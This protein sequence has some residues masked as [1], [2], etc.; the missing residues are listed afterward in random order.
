V[1]RATAVVIGAGQAGLAM[2]RCLSEF[3]VD[4]AVLERGQVAERWRAT[5]WDSLR[6]LT[7]NWMTRLPGFRYDGDDPDGFM[8]ATDLISM[9]ER[10][11]LISEAPVYRGTTVNAVE[12]GLGGFRIATD[13]GDWSAS[14][15]VI[16]TGYCDVPFVPAMHAQLSPAIH[17]LVP[18]DY[19]SPE[20]L[21][22]GGVLIVGAS[23]TG[24][25]LADEL[26]ASGREVVLAVG[27][28]TRLPRRY[29]GRDILWWLDRLGLLDAPI[30]AVH[31]IAISRDK[32]SLQ[33][34]GRADCATIDLASLHARGARVA[35]RLIAID[36]HHARFDSDLTGTTAAADVKLAEIR[37]RIDQ[38]IA[39]HEVWAAAP[40]PFVPTWPMSMDGPTD[41]DLDAEGIR[42]VIWATGFRRAYPWLRI[43][44]LDR[45]GEIQHRAGNTPYP[46]LYVL[47]LNFQRRRNS[48]F[49]D[50]V[51]S[52]ARF[53]AREL[54]A[55]LA[56]ARSAAKA[57]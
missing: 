46:A 12:P 20:Q 19:R 49:I 32:P 54:A 39:A 8:P 35:G 45:S 36:R 25:Q 13:R 4:H 10:Y 43:P 22:D 9:L 40:E 48:S 38:F 28:H 41:L 52:D 23:A 15:V 31:D 7:P 30:E 5:S 55:T 21:P 47:G 24:V 51:G 14:A 53:I 18:G 29:R 2:S 26:H 1:R 56:T 11:A 33:L 3:G 27:R 57:S 6:L 37:G 42:T 17:Q 16:A 44:V 34:V 50:G